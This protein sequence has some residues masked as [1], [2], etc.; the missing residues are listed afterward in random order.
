MFTREKRRDLKYCQQL[1]KCHFFG[2]FPWSSDSYLS[3]TCSVCF[4]PR[5]GTGL[6]SEMSFG[7]REKRLVFTHGHQDSAIS[8][9]WDSSP[10]WGRTSPLVSLRPWSREPPLSDFPPH[11]QP[12]TCPLT[13]RNTPPPSLLMF[14]LNPWQKSSL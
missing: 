14:Y 13:E 3:S 11:P 5:A 7:S 8:L 10:G 2:D 6:F 4:P 12:W 9:Q 1:T